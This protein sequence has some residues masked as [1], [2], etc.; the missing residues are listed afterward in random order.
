MQWTTVCVARD[1][2]WAVLFEMFL[3]TSSTFMCWLRGVSY[4]TRGKVGRVG[5]GVGSMAVEAMLLDTT[6]IVPSTQQSSDSLIEET[7]SLFALMTV[8]Y[9]CLV[10]FRCSSSTGSVED[11]DER[12][13]DSDS[14]SISSGPVSQ[15]S[16]SS[17]ST[18]P[19]SASS[20]A[21][22]TVS[23]VWQPLAAWIHS[24]LSLFIA[25]S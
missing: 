15:C 9:I 23:L 16:P 4:N 24:C 3:G 10:H 6:V 8:Q 7:V 11:E 13:E 12:L 1:E 2:Q 14:A 22:D 25:E 17:S 19:S 18:S 5:W 20:S 21:S